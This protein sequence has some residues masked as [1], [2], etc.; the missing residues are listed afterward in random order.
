[1]VVKPL[2]GYFS[3]RCR[4]HF[5]RRQPFMLCAFIGVVF[6]S[7]L[8]GF[9]TDLWSQRLGAAPLAPGAHDRTTGTLFRVRVLGGGRAGVLGDRFEVFFCCFHLLFYWNTFGF[10]GT[11]IF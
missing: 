1:M 10:V 2:V 4:L 7:L 5:E 6:A 11:L 8:I 3:D 9:A